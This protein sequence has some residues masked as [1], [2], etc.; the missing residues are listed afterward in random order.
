MNAY[1]E[2]GRLKKAIA[3]A[4]C[5]TKYGLGPAYLNAMNA[6]QWALAAEA[7]GVKIPSKATQAKVYEI[8][9]QREFPVKVQS[10]DVAPEPVAE[11]VVAIAS[12]DFCLECSQYRP[13]DCDTEAQYLDRQENPNS[14]LRRDVGY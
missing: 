10:D 2:L 14:S 1:E 9:M 13:C 11:D 4:D 6:E 5:F 3:L 12:E 8:L 7:A